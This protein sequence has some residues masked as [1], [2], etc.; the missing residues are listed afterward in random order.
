MLLAALIL[1]FFLTALSFDRIST[2]CKAHQSMQPFIPS[3]QPY[4]HHFGTYLRRKS[5]FKSPLET[6]NDEEWLFTF[7]NRAAEGQ[8]RPPHTT[9]QGTPADEKAGQRG[10]GKQP[11]ATTST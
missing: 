9:Q 5:S 10:Y 4:S 1:R 7:R 11:C 8:E 3:L 2:S 6:L